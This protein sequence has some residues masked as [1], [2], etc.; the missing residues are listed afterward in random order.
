[1]SVAM[2]QQR[3]ASRLFPPQPP[4][5]AA[6]AARRLA[7]EER[8]RQKRIIVFCNGDI[9]FKGKKVS[10]TPHRYLSY[11]DLLQDL[12][13]RMPQHLHLPNGVRQLFSPTSG[14]RLADVADLKDGGVYVCAGNET[15]KPVTYGATEV[16]PWAR[17]RRD[18]QASQKQQPW[19]QRPQPPPPPQPQSLFA[20]Y[21]A[22]PPSRYLKHQ[23][24]KQQQSAQQLQQQQQKQKPSLS[25]ARRLQPQQQQQQQQPV[26][27]QPRLVTIVK[28]GPRPRQVVKMLLN[29]RGI[30]SFAQ[31]L[32]DI[33][34]SFGGSRGRRERLKKIFTIAGREIRDV[35]DLFRDDDLFVGCVEDAIE[36]AQVEDLLEELYPGNP[37]VRDL[38]NDWERR[39][40]RRQMRRQQMQQHRQQPR[41]HQQKQQQQQQKQPQQQQRLATDER[42]SGYDES[43]LQALASVREHQH[44]QPQQHRTA[45]AAKRH[46]PL[47]LLRNSADVEASEAA[48]LAEA[49]AEAERRARERQAAAEAAAEAASAKRELPRAHV[50]LPPI[51]AS[52]AS[53][54]PAEEANAEKATDA[55]KPPP[56][57]GEPPQL[58]PVVLPRVASAA[59]EDADDDASE[60]GVPAVPLSP[61]HEE[62][63]AEAAAEATVAAA[64]AA[65]P[66]ASEPKESAAEAAAPTDRKRPL[67]RPISSTRYVFERYDLGRTL[68]DGNFAVVRACVK[69]DSGNEYA[70]KVIDKKKLRGKEH[71]VLN[72]VR[73][74]RLCRHP[75]IVRLVDEYETKAEIY[76][77]MELV[78]GG[79]LFDA[80]SQVVKFNEIQASSMVADIAGALHYLHSRRIV[81]RDLKPEN[82]LVYRS[83]DNKISLKL[84]DFGLAMEVEEAIFTVCGTPTYVAP[85]ILSETGYG[86]EVDMWA[87]GVIAY[88]LL[89]GF[90]PFRSRDRRQSELFQMIKTG[91]F[92]Y[93]SPYWDHVSAPAKDLINRLLV[94]DKAAR[95]TAI[96][97]LCHAWV[98][99]RGGSQRQ[100]QEQQTD[101]AALKDEQSRLRDQL[102]AEAAAAI[103]EFSKLKAS[104]LYGGVT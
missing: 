31:L 48:A 62:A 34:D 4:D 95:L 99:S 70:A 63:A 58:E 102:V 28:E 53:A 101:S 68:G 94:V 30:Q 27:R 9:F 17:G 44:Q 19:L 15:F 88:I 8:R 86:L 20:G 87:L 78:K 89:C 65:E 93:L 43:D 83:K 5:E 41:L 80:I 13:A 92:E 42:D 39:L 61:V 100:E 7:R 51:G 96:D 90:P 67:I 66:E 75:N 55:E 47:P 12:T 45:A 103:E 3:R 59:Q 74:M 37:G 32:S 85:E 82:L 49:L 73:I 50:V 69:R 98:L 57:E 25:L 21:N 72:E 60:S 24:G 11:N 1:M 36:I 54:E 6:V 97:V 77:I 71:M 38:L 23:R 26:Q 79:D 2:S 46:Q 104:S 16:T 18:S 22:F 84:G 91:T 29:R 64:A 35:G 52:R 40:K 76:L 81:H 10:I 56:Q 33:S 14:R